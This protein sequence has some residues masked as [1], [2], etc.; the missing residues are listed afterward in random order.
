[1]Q[2]FII[3]QHVSSTPDFIVLHIGTNSIS[4]CGLLT[5]FIRHFTE[6]IQAVQGKFKDSIILVSEL[7]V[8]DDLDILSYNLHLRD[9]CRSRNINFIA[10][11][12]TARDLWFDGLH[13]FQ[14]GYEQM[15]VD[16]HHA[17]KR[18]VPGVNEQSEQVI[19]T[20]PC[21]I[22][23]LVSKRKKKKKKQHLK[24]AKMSRP[25]IGPSS[26]SQNPKQ[27]SRPHCRRRVASY[28]IFGGDGFR[29]IGWKPLACSLSSEI[30]PQLPLPAHQPLGQQYSSK[31]MSLPTVSSSPYVMKRKAA[32]K[33]KKKM[34]RVRKRR[35]RRKRR[36]VRFY[37]LCLA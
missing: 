19:Q 5:R 28:S 23:P 31:R 20:P 15:A 4:Q 34:K 12:I 29:V 10:S 13:L 26:K 7:F 8:R 33:K 9:L 6:L 18:M 27:S 3:N 22:P 35:A 17:I 1:M 11:S 14:E 16:L 37:G 24:E 36:K 32:T 30:E 25:N 2:N 21:M